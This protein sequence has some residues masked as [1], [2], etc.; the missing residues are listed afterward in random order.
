MDSPDGT[1]AYI[2]SA[3]EEHE[4]GGYMPFAIL[5]ANS[6]QVLGST[7][8]DAL[9]MQHR[10]LEVGWTFLNPGIWRSAVNTE[11]KCLLLGYAFDH[12]ECIRV[13]FKTDS[14]NTRPRAAI[15]RLGAKQEGSLRAH[16]LCADGSRRDMVYFSI[17]EAEWP[18]VPEG[19]ESRLAAD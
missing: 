9:A 19:L 10:R 3:Q 16:I 15:L 5:E 2:Q 12:L 8:Y 18:A 17:L 6:E 13:E 14:R 4:L 7:R 1:E 11:C